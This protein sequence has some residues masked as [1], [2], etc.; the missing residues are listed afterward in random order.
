VIPAIDGDGHEPTVGQ[1]LQAR[2]QLLFSSPGAVQLNHHGK[3]A[4]R[5]LGFDE[6]ADNSLSSVDRQR[7][8]LLHEAWCARRH[9]PDNR[10]GFHTRPIDH[11]QERRSRFRRCWC[12]C[13]EH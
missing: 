5:A 10:R 9:R 12:L 3:T 4:L 6:D 8:V 13:V 2:Q 7:D 11:L 1:H